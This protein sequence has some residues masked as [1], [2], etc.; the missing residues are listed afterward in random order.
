MVPLCSSIVSRGRSCPFSWLVD[1]VNHGICA[2]LLRT[3]VA[4]PRHHTA[5][6]PHIR[7][8]SGED[9][10]VCCAIDASD[11]LWWDSVGTLEIR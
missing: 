10:R 9:Y 11:M 1:V 8:A 5:D 7:A 4:L 2:G 6:C 3:V